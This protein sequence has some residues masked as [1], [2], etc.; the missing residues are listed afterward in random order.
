LNGI[1]EMIHHLDPAWIY[2]FV[3]LV[4]FGENLF[5]PFP[6]DVILVFCGYLS[7]VDRVHWLLLLVF[8]YLGSVVGFML[9]HGIGR[10]LDQQIVRSRKWRWLPYEP[11]E[12]VE[13]W[14]GRYGVTIIIINRF[15][16]GVRTAIA[17]VSGMAR[18]DARITL[19]CATISV[20]TWNAIL[21]LSGKWLGENWLEVHQ[22]LLEYQRA[23]II[24]GAL[25]VLVLAAR[26][27]WKAVVKSSG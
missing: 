20:G 24:A 7:G 23:L 3:V 19:L 11:I 2:L 27:V 4:T 22:A 12:K 8:A 17:I 25:V 9:L 6:G 1:L 18:I 14:F 10:V 16:M 5:P 15:L 13:R 26:Y 21:V